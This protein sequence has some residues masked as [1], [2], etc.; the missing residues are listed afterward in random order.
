MSVKVWQ[1][2]VIIPTYEVGKPEK[3]PIFLEKRVYQGSSGKVYPNP[4]I[5][6]IYDEKI[7]KAYSAIWM[8]NKY[9][10]IM[11]LPE[12]GGRVQMAYDKIKERHFVYYNNVIKP[13]LVGLTGPW[14]SGGIEF[15]WPQH[16]RPSTFEATDYKIE[17]NADGS[18]TAWCSEVEKMF[19]Q[20]GM[21]GFTLHPDK[22]YLEIRVKLYNRSLL[23]QTFLWWANPAVVV[24]DGYQ[25]VFPPDVWGVYDH[26]KRDS[27]RFPIATG[28]YY[29]M[30]YSSG[31]D[32]SRYKNIPVP[33]SYMAVKSDYCFMGGYENDAKGG[34][35][36]VADR[37]QSPGKK[38]WTWGH[39]DFGQAWDRNLTDKDGPYIEI[40]C[41]VYTDNQ[42]D[43]SWLMPNEQ[44]TFTQYFMPYQELGLVKNASKEA[45]VTMD[46]EAAKASFKVYVTGDYTDLKVNIMHKGKTIY[47]KT[48]D[49]TPVHVL[50]DTVA[51]PI[52]YTKQDVSIEVIDSMGRE[53]VAWT[54]DEE[55]I[56]PTPPPATAAPE[57]EQLKTN[58]ELYLHGLHLEQIRHATYNP[59]AYYEEALKRDPSDI[60]NNNAKGLLLMRRG[61]L[62]EAETYFKRAVKKTTLRNP[63]PYDG[64]PLYNLGICQKLMGNYTE[65]YKNLYKA[66]W[67]AAWKDSGYF[68]VAQITC[69]NGDFAL[70]LE[71]AQDAIE[72]N[73]NSHK[74]RSLKASI[75]RHL[76]RYEEALDWIEDSLEIDQFNM[77]SRYEQYLIESIQGHTTEADESLNELKA[78]M[79]GHINSYLE[80]A[81]DYGNAGLYTEAFDFLN[82]LAEGKAENQYPMVGYM[83]GAY[84]Q[85][86]GDLTLA[87]I[88]FEAAQKAPSTYCFPNKLEEMAALQ[89]A[90]TTNPNDGMAAYY[91]GNLFYDKLQ[92]SK[93]V[94]LW[95]SAAKQQPAFPTVWRNLALAYYNKLDKKE[96]AR[97]VLEKAFALDTTDHR[98]LMELDQLYRKIGKSPAE[99]LAFLEQHPAGV[100][101][102]DDLYLEVVT[103]NNT[104]ENYDKAY[105]L[106]MSRHFHPWEGGEG[107]VVGQYLHSIIEKAKLYLADNK[108]ELALEW[109]AK[110]DSYPHNLGEGKLYGTSENDINYWKG[111]A[112]KML[113]N[114][115]HAQLFF[116][117]AQKGSSEPVQAFFY[118]DQ[119]PDKILYQGL[120]ARLLG[121]EKEARTIF[122]KMKNHGE[123]H[124]F[125]TVKIDYFAVSLPDLAIFDEDFNNRNLMHCNY[126]MGLS[127]YGL[128]DNEKA[129]AY[130]TK[131]L[132]LDQNHLGAQ[133]HLAMCCV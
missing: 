123:E 57:P 112:Y 94:V 31:V 7:D 92:Y 122:N 101:E 132:E 86:N 22:A 78:L 84:A 11:L 15:N 91:L 89:I 102:R 103:L 50:V 104:L 70:A 2:Q 19:N 80:Y 49:M 96:E 87:K 105:A 90:L 121:N 35:L 100:E 58:E 28:T 47:T 9:V 133:L 32:I 67:N 1:E 129:K 106:L 53:L 41:G 74:A 119:Q 128:G 97:L 13:A 55:E 130:L 3:N 126:I 85:L 110:T 54:P 75:L 82:I 116:K 115:S 108:A 81:I 125:E 4:V 40:M 79:R 37:N 20:K 61:A 93:A 88:Y 8:E 107:K 38:Q 5:E 23:P 117:L 44:K 76:G 73:W 131:V 65:A 34:I 30:D 27:S 16:H 120:A 6:K 113:G 63:N 45:M 72:R 66:T 124:I 118:N 114:E 98:I 71:H 111:I 60:R 26:G 14:I 99:R 62:E 77:S 127:Y 18:I 46:F 51:L 10:K 25:S 43:F 17:E 109:L 21:A 68:A 48:L 29:K 33:T 24:N 69:I 95:E 12:L 52:G 59:M 56:H 83:M 36:H 39:S 64:E 42:P